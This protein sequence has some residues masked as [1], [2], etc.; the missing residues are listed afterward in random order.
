MARPECDKP[1]VFI[2]LNI[3][4]FCFSCDTCQVL[5]GYHEKINTKQNVRSLFTLGKTSRQKT[6]RKS[7][8]CHLMWPLILVTRL[9]ICFTLGQWFVFWANFQQ[10]LTSWIWFGPIYTGSFMGKKMAQIHQILKKNNF[11]IAIIS[12][13]G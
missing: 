7:F 2:K 11:I 8:N 3:I 5:I 10:I 12:S 9:A 4:K 1:L 6:L 13:S